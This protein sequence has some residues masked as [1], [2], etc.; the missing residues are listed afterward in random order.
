VILFPCFLMNCSKITL[1][2]VS[3]SLQKFGGKNPGF[4]VSEA[5]KTGFLICQPQSIEKIHLERG[6]KPG[7]SVSEAAKTRF[8]IHQTPDY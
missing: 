7:F 2:L 8:L 1:Q 6:N 3:V 4:L 5:T